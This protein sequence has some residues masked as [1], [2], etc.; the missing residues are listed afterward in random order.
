MKKQKTPSTNTR[1]NTRR[2]LRKDLPGSD[3]P[4]TPKQIFFCKEYLI[5]L[6]GAQAARRAGF[7]PK[8]ADVTASQL[9][10][11]PNIQALIVKLKEQR[12]VR[13]EVTADEVLRELKRIGFANMRDF[14]K[15][16]SDQVTLEDSELLTEDQTA[17]VQTLSQTTTKDGGSIRFQLH[18]KP[19]ALELMA[20]HL[21]I[22]H[23]KIAVSTDDVKDIAK[24]MGDVVLKLVPKNQVEACLTEITD[25][26]TKN[27]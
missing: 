21:G 9:L 22:L 10:V 5:D 7:N 25:I 16:D 27:E 4:L 6:N 14:A 11:K 19:K 12:A 13:I 18:D 23:D 26:L 8:T 15:W 20:R 1:G 17:A 24:R 3:K 2:E